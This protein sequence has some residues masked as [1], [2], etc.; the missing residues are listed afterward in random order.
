MVVPIEPHPDLVPF[1]PAARRLLTVFGAP[2]QLV[3]V[4][5]RKQRHGRATAARPAF[6]RSPAARIVGSEAI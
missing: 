5:E 2:V 1:A 4:P 6:V 3:Y